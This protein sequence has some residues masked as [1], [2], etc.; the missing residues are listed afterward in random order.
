MK[1]SIFLFLNQNP[2]SRS[3]ERR[4][5]GGLSEGNLHLTVVPQNQYVI[6]CRINTN[7]SRRKR[8]SERRPRGK[9]TALFW[10]QTTHVEFLMRNEF[11]KTISVKIH[12][13]THN[14]QSLTKELL[15]ACLKCSKPLKLSLVVIKI[16]FQ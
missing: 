8:F 15:P 2:C 4:C 9:I 1:G 16:C 13:A 5:S 11:G 10:V 3:P 12:K 14:L 7:G 6:C